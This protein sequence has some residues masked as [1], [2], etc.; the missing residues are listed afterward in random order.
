MKCSVEAVE[1]APFGVPEHL[2]SFELCV[3]SLWTGLR[4]QSHPLS[5]PEST[6]EPTCVF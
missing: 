2:P 6:E 1:D 5:Q 3:E 4:T